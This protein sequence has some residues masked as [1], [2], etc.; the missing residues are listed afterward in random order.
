VGRIILHHNP[1]NS[2]AFQLQMITIILA[3]TVLCISIYITLEHVC[4][5]INP[6]LSRIKP[7]LYLIIFLPLDLGCLALQAVGGGL[8]AASAQDDER[9][10]LLPHGNR[11][12]IAGIALQV[13]MLSCFGLL[14]ADYLHRAHSY[15]HGSSE[16][17]DPVTLWNSKRFRFF[18]GAV[19]VAYLGILVR[20]IYR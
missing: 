18:G 12:I 5:S 7:K 11:A 16:S 4:V 15:I 17:R 8:A 6:L 2:T 13:A 19:A 10:A 14:C 20:C 3:P 1:W 9:R